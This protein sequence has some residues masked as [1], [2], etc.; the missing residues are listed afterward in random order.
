MSTATKIIT[1]KKFTP[2]FGS[3]LFLGDLSPNCTKFDIKMLFSA[4]GLVTDVK[5]IVK[6][7][8]LVGYGFVTMHELFG[9]TAALCRLQGIF[10][11]GRQL[12]VRWAGNNIRENHLFNESV[13][14][15]IH[16]R[17]NALNQNVYVNEEVLWLFFSVYGAIDI[18]IK[19]NAYD[20]VSFPIINF[21]LS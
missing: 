8:Q 14:N 7:K 6:K 20:K 21:S 3:T 11:C 9:A 2:S 16:V 18:C 10:L 4:F 13:V 15:S 12:R 1:T 19:K 17:F 5:I